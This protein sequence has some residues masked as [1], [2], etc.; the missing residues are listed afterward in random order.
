VDK[1][2]FTTITKIAGLFLK[3]NLKNVSVLGM[4]SRASPILGIGCTTELYPTPSIP[5][6]L[7]V[8]FWQ[9]FALSLDPHPQPHMVIFIILKT[10]FPGLDI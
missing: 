2:P 3:N 1:K 5:G 9:C 4:E 7:C 8:C 6:F 10:K